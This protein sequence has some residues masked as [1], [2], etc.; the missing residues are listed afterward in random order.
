MAANRNRIVA[1][2]QRFLQKAQYDKALVEYQRLLEDDP[3]DIRTLLK[4]GDVYVKMGDNASAADTFI[5]IATRYHEEGS[6]HKAIAVFKQVVKLVPARV[7]ALF[8]LSELYVEV[9][10]VQEAAAGFSELAKVYEGMGRTKEMCAVYR[11]VVELEPDDVAGRVRLAELCVREEM[12]DEAVAEFRVILDHLRKVHRRAD[13]IKVAERLL[14][15]DSNDLVLIKELARLYVDK[16]DAQRA[17]A[18]LQQGFRAAPRDPEILELLAD[19]FRDLGQLTKTAAVLREL[20]SVFDESGSRSQ[21]DAALQR[22]LEIE[23]GD[24][25]ARR[26]LSA[27]AP[28]ADVATD[29]VQPTW[30]RADAASVSSATE[31]PLEPGGEIEKRLTEI[32]IYAKYGLR[33]Q[34][35]REGEALA[36][37]FPR[38][39]KVA[40]LLARIYEE[41]GAL[42][43]AAHALARFGEAMGAELGADAGP[44]AAEVFRLDPTSIWAAG[45]FGTGGAGKSSASETGAAPGGLEIE[46]DEASLVFDVDAATRTSVDLADVGAEAVAI[47]TDFD[48]REGDVEFSASDA[49]LPKPAGADRPGSVAPRV[50][51]DDDDVGL[52]PVEAPSREANRRPSAAAVLTDSSGSVAAM[53]VEPAATSSLTVSPEATAVL[54]E[55]D[56]FLIQGLHDEAASMLRE[57]CLRWPG[58]VALTIKLREI[59]MVGRTAIDEPTVGEVVAQLRRSEEGAGSD[60]VSPGDLASDFSFGASSLVDD[61]S[62]ETHFDLGRAYQDMSLWDEAIDEYRCALLEPRLAMEA[63]TALATCFR[64]AGRTSEALREIDRVLAVQSLTSAQKRAAIFERAAVFEAMGDMSAALN[65]Y[66]S[67]AHE[68]PKYRDVEARMHRLSAML[69]GL[70]SGGSVTAQGTP[71]ARG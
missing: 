23:P 64:Q 15:Y 21:R 50:A 59:E 52:I 39:E 47:D 56:F 20:V 34:S 65:G 53:V 31:A 55:V 66:R 12:R 33:E 43:L 10:L 29:A 48:E 30:D 70:G 67:V 4:V 51:A 37:A 58:Q 60:A 49:V 19:T 38:E 16:G 40:R 5:R 2:A 44:L 6:V 28:E 3:K 9:G 7:D 62:A 1:A 18:R 8:S 27:E 36:K 22:L 25:D 45:V 41:S 46:V 68:D 71:K 14:Y 11:R 24:E 13:F 17:L 32:E 69:G 63:G 57:A 61:Q 42:A 54:E 35:V 26:Q